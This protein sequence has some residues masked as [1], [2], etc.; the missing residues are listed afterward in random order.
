MAT[1]HRVFEHP[2]VIEEI[3][4]GKR[5]RHRFDDPVEVGD[6]VR[7]TSVCGSEGIRA[8]IHVSHVE[9]GPDEQTPYL[10]CWNGKCWAIR[11]A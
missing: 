11:T 5:V 7:F 8:F 10:I 2:Q 9:V 4:S 3:I 1:K 6:T